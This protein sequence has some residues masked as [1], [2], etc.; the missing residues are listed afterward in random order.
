MY[1]IVKNKFDKKIKLSYSKNEYPSNVADIKHNLI[2][3]TFKFMKIKD[4]IEFI[5]L[6]DIHSHGTGLGS[7]SAFTLASLSS[8]NSFLDYKP[9]S[10][11]KLAQHAC[12]IEINKNK[13]P[14]GY[15]D[16]YASAFGGFNFIKFNKSDVTLKKF[17]FSI[18]ELNYLK[19]SLVLFNTNIYRQTNSILSNHLSNIKNQVNVSYLDELYNETILLYENLIN[20]RFHFIADSLNRS[21][22]LKKKFNNKTTNPQIDL[23]VAKGLKNGAKGAKLLGAGNGGF[24]L[25]FIDLKIRNNFISVMG[26]ENILDFDF[27]NLGTVSNNFI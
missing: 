25:F 9:L 7:S 17:K 5:S 22:E 24:I 8:L 16:Q 1:V 4:N 3:H 10:K 27:D 11:K 21:W 20:K 15:Q 26:K 2:K 18:S 12:Y 13:S 6:A 19:K 14:I 23:L